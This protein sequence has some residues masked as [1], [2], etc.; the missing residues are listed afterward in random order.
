V[1]ALASNDG[2]SQSGILDLK[3][4]ADLLLDLENTLESESIGDVASNAKNK[5][6]SMPSLSGTASQM[7]SILKLNK[8]SK[9][10]D[11]RVAEIVDRCDAVTRSNPGA[12]LANGATAQ[13][14]KARALYAKARLLI[15]IIPSLN[16]FK[17]KRSYGD[18]ID[19]LSQ[20]TQSCPNQATYLAAGFCLSKIK[21]RQAAAAALQ[22]CIA[23][24]E[25][26]EYAVEAARMQR[27]LGLR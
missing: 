17:R 5:L 24:D 14:I 18:A 15:T 21:D 6:L 13:E 22:N 7:K 23:L 26:S 16:T 25:E 27:D 3:L 12:A 20:S 1:I 19:I 8:L 10:T 9:T 4:A 2:S 11:R